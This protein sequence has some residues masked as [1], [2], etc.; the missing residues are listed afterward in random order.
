MHIIHERNASHAK[1]N[2]RRAVEGSYFLNLFQSMLIFHS[3]RTQNFLDFGHSLHTFVAYYRIFKKM[4]TRWLNSLI[5]K[6]I[7]FKNNRLLRHI[8]PS[9]SCFFVNYC[10]YLIHSPLAAAST[11]C[12]LYHNNKIIGYLKRAE[13]EQKLYKSVKLYIIWCNF[14]AS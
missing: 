4:S 10:Y 7:N 8:S 3:E 1:T 11:E 13:Q 9:I 2:E 14:H 5:L 12:H 6:L